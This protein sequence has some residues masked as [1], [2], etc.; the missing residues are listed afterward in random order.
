MSEEEGGEVGMVVG[1]EPEGAET[2]LQ[3]H[4]GQRVD[5][6]EQAASKHPDK[7]LI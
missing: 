5:G 7:T 4:Q 3:A 2:D 1:L 6:Q